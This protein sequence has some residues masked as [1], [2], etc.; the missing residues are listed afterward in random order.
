[1]KYHFWVYKYKVLNM[2]IKHCHNPYPSRFIIM[3]WKMTCNRTNVTIWRQIKSLTAVP[4]M[5]FDCE[6]NSRTSTVGRQALWRKCDNS[7][8]SNHNN[9]NQ[10]RLSEFDP[11]DNTTQQ[12][13][14]IIEI[15]D[16][17]SWFSSICWTPQSVSLLSVWEKW[18]FHGT[19]YSFSYVPP[20]QQ[21]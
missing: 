15:G 7:H 1:M 10:Q 4:F 2:I 16:L 9:Q 8:Q 12:C 6:M 3:G 17:S 11:P 20:L 13:Q 18:P 14:S 5:L 21:H 19:P